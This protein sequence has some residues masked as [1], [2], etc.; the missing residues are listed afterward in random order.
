MESGGAQQKKFTWEVIIDYDEPKI[1]IIEGNLNWAKDVNT[2]E[3]HTRSE[4]KH[5]ER[6]GTW[7]DQLT[8]LETT[9]RNQTNRGSAPK[10]K[11]D[12]IRSQ[13]HRDEREG[14]L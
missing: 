8:G 11:N 14:Q 12:D 2:V 7:L 13:S 4:W 5:T 10:C 3:E 1:G 9:W 6:N